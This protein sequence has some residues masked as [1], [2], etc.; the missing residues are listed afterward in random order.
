MARP[1]SSNTYKTLSHLSLP[2]T[3]SIW[4]AGSEIRSSSK[5][6]LIY[7]KEIRG[8]VSGIN[9]LSPDQGVESER[10]LQPKEPLDWFRTGSRSRHGALSALE[11][12]VPLEQQGM[13]RALRDLRSDGTS[14]LKHLPWHKTSRSLG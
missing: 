14:S 5:A 8:E 11:C 3:D 6:Y 9:I 2:V 10:R 1:P 12:H 7:R 13:G 4:S